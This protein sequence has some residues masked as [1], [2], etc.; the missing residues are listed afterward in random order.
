MQKTIDGGF[1]ITRLKF[2]SPVEKT[3]SVTEAQR[4]G[5]G[6]VNSPS[7][8]VLRTLCSDPTLQV[9]GVPMMVLKT[10][11]IFEKKW[12]A[13]QIEAAVACPILEGSVSFTPDTITWYLPCQVDP[14]ISSGQFKLLEVHMGV[15]GQRL[16][17]AE[18]AA[19]QY[20]LFLNDLHVVVQIPVG[21]AGGHF[22]S[23]VQDNQYFTSYMVT[24]MVELLWTED[25]THE[26][27]R[28]KVLFPI[29]TPFLSRPPQVIDNTVP[30]Q[31]LFKVLVGPF[32][33]DVALMNITFPSEILSVTDCVARGFSI[34]EHISPNSSSK[35]F[36]L[37]VP[38][39]DPVRE[40]S[41]MVYSLHPTF[42]LLVLPEF[43]PFSV[44]LTVN[45]VLL[46][47]V[48]PPS[49]SGGC[50]YKNFYVLVKYGTQGFNFQT[51]LGKQILT[52]GLAQQYNLIENGTH[53]SMAIPFSAPAVVFEA[54]ESSSIR[55]RLDVVLQNLETK[56]HMKAFTLA[57][58]FPST[59]TE[60]FPN[61]TITSVAVKVESVPSLDPSKLT[62]R[63]PSCG[64]VYSNEHYAYFVFTANSCGTTRKFF[65]N[66]MM[67]VNE[68]SLPDELQK[69]DPNSEEDCS[70][71]D[72]FS[73]F[74]KVEDYPTAKYLQQPLYFEVELMQ[75]N[76]PKVSLELE[77][78][79]ATQKEDRT[80]EPRWNFIID[81]CASPADPY[82]VLFHPVWVDSRV[83]Y[84]SHFKRFEVQMFAFAEDQENL[85]HQLF[86]HCDVV[87][88]DARNPLGGVCNGQC[89]NQ[90]N[91][92]KG[93]T[94][95][96]MRFSSPLTIHGGSHFIHHIEIV[97]KCFIVE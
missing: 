7:R 84:P 14:L 8:L 2:F 81:G 53:L 32:G 74:H 87:I 80:S 9:A 72:S 95:H 26:E 50:D 76:N 75:S 86:V 67:Y 65:P 56:Q 21:A 28:Y 85:G 17:A 52:S 24:P 58:N 48:V 41:T 78:C 68:I 55:G 39:T 35:V 47:S 83:Q 5:Y 60:C 42:G 18:M 45:N 64:P 97:L 57:C 6:I 92:P 29:A 59:L 31:W 89:P 33:S 43:T 12:L 20:T 25:D 44:T 37:E 34:L 71:Y 22:K 10:S 93:R 1:R 40:M 15:D 79:W 19:R 46:L 11:A 13:T 54:V 82:Q 23:H 94:V 66:A 62:L 90:E 30:E 77:N 91:R 70:G 88:C 4:S 61:G 49:I 16:D 38:F 27:T 3:M 51:M 36:T 69:T 96:H 73:V 63:D